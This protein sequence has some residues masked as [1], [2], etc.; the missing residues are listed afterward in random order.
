VITTSSSLYALVLTFM[1][2]NFCVQYNSHNCV[3]FQVFTEVDIQ[4]VVFKVV[5]VC[6]L[7]DVYQ[8]LEEHATCA[9]RVCHFNPVDESSIPP[10]RW[11]RPTRPIVL[12]S[13]NHSQLS[14][15]RRTSQ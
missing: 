14:H 10:K 13:R 1:E 4:S 11:Y 5:A 3:R 2:F 8:H 9:F 15:L 12:Q 7:V 6:G